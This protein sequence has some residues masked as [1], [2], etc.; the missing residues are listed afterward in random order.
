M[1][2]VLDKLVGSGLIGRFESSVFVVHVGL[3]LGWIPILLWFGDFFVVG[4]NGNS[5]VST[6][7]IVL[8]TDR[9]AQDRRDN[10]EDAVSSS[11]A[12]VLFLMY[13]ALVVRSSL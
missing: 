11:G 8:G 3:E 2:L 5:H 9:W 10:F 4:R 12:C 13:A 1:S 6:K 7:L